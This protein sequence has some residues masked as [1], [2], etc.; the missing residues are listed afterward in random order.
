MRTFV[1]SPKYP[2]EVKKGRY[3]DFSNVLL[4]GETVTSATVTSVPSNLASNKSVVGNKV[5]F[6]V[7]GGSPRTTITITVIATGSLGTVAE[8]Q[9]T[10]YVNLPI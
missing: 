4:T 9:G 7:T 5:L 10:M 2:L 6:D 3:F 1:F 8:A